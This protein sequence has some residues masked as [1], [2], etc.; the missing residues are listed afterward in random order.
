MI[1]AL[2]ERDTEVLG[3]LSATPRK[4]EGKLHCPMSL[5]LLQTYAS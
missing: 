4:E 5:Q 1:G 2:H 3:L